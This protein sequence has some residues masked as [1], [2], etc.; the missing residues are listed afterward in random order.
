[1]S[2]F[3][4]VFVTD[5]PYGLSIAFPAVPNLT[6]SDLMRL[7]QFLTAIPE[8]AQLTKPWQLFLEQKPWRKSDSG[9]VT[10]VSSLQFSGMDAQAINPRVPFNSAKFPDETEISSSSD[11][12]RALKF[13]R[14]SH[15]K[16]FVSVASTFDQTNAITV[17]Y[18]TSLEGCDDTKDWYWQRF[19]EELQKDGMLGLPIAS[20]PGPTFAKKCFI[21]DYQLHVMLLEEGVETT[22]CDGPPSYFVYAPNA[23]MKFRA[24]DVASVHRMITMCYVGAT[25][26]RQI[27]GH[28]WMH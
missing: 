20:R 27:L 19:L 17:S 21:G 7:F 26:T 14:D 6:D 24:E 3:S 8:G 22:E 5:L 10:V 28:D 18:E 9:E 2:E 13:A 25:V 15:W 11:I 4:E 12:S 23:V 16:F 1:M